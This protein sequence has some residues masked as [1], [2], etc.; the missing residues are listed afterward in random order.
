[1]IILCCSAGV[2]HHCWSW[3][4]WYGLAKFD[5]RAITWSY[6]TANSHYQSGAWQRLSW[7]LLMAAS[8]GDLLVQS[9]NDSIEKL[10]CTHE[11][12][13]SSSYWGNSFI[14]EM[15]YTIQAFP[16]KTLSSVLFLENHS[17]TH[18]KPR[19]VNLLES[20]F[21]TLH[22][23]LAGARNTRYLAEI[24]GLWLIKTWNANQGLH[25][26][27]SLCKWPETLLAVRKGLV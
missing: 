18:S 17:N 8:S 20:K 24:P 9:W 1:M 10:V 12:D 14:Q 3:V 26:R 21:A 6:F 15:A 23:E 5:C 11:P 22:G 13:F 25:Q 19:W 16:Q 4:H 2:S 27:T 7:P